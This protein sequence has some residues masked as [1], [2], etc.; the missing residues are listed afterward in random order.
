ME[1]MLGSCGK[2]AQYKKAVRANTALKTI[3]Y[4]NDSVFRVH[5]TGNKID[6]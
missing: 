3:T 4:A 6:E 5:F 1:H 2:M